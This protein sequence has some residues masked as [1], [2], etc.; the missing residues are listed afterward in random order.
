MEFTNMKALSKDKNYDER[1]KC[2]KAMTI[3]ANQIMNF[4]Y[5]MKTWDLGRVVVNFGREDA[6]YYLRSNS[7]IFK[8]IVFS[9]IS[10]LPEI[11]A[12]QV[13]EGESGEVSINE[14]LKD[15]KSKINYAPGVLRAVGL[16]NS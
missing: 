12:F 6:E 9:G 13:Q 16:L 4:A 5:H 1:E 2:F 11:Y 15:L 14:L 10:D 3:S 8:K 7:D